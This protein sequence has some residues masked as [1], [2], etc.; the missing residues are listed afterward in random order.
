[1]SPVKPVHR[2]TIKA[3]LLLGFGLTVGLWIFTGVQFTRRMADVERDANAISGR[4]MNAQ[5][6]LSTVRVQVLIG[7]VYARD[8]LLDPNPASAEAYQQRLLSTYEAVDS[9][10][11]KYVPVLDTSAERARVSRLREEVSTF[12]STLLEVL[13]SRTRQG[14]TDARILL[15]QRIVPR[16]EVVIRVSEEVQALNREAFVEQQAGIA[17]I[18]RVMQRRVWQ[19]LGLALVASLGI[20]LLASFYSGRLERQLRRERER[21]VQKTQDLQRL[22]AKLITAQEEERRSIAREL[23]DEVGQALTAIKMELAVA[24]TAID[25]SGAPARVLEDARAI[26]EGALHSIRDLSLLLRPTILDDL[27]LRAALDWYVRET[28]K[29]YHLRVT[30]TGEGAETRLAV[31]TEVAAFRIVQE[32][33]TNVVKHAQATACRIHLDQQADLLRVT[34]EDDGVGFDVTDPPSPEERR[35]LGLLGIRER[36]AYLRGTVGIERG[37]RR[38]T[39]ITVELPAHHRSPAALPGGSV[40][41]AIITG[42]PV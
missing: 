20:A 41:Q 23:H 37:A 18:Y 34:I 10:L 2:L 31:E 6:L 4:Y 38:G 32:A 35:G 1:M 9:A 33:L 28:N 3:A 8:A 36:A 5:E 39:R 25:A 26:T 42:V 27:G 7:S 22:S 29:R 16:R 11:G 12:R 40:G 14:S 15:Q 13:E 24:Q 19:Q 17:E 21:D 30:L